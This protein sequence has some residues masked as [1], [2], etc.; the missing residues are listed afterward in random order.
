[1][2]ELAGAKAISAL[3]AALPGGQIT[4]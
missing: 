2:W 3:A 1:M 4:Y